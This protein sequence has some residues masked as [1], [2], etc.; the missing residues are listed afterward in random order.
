[1]GRTLAGIVAI[2]LLSGVSAVASKLEHPETPGFYRLGIE[3]ILQKPYDIPGQQPNQNSKLHIA[4]EIE[5]QR[6]LGVMG[7]LDY[8][9]TEK[10]LKLDSSFDIGDHG[11]GLNIQLN[12][13]WFSDVYL[14]AQKLNLT[15]APTMAWWMENAGQSVANIQLDKYIKLMI[16]FADEFYSEGYNTNGVVSITKYSAPYHSQN[17]F[18]GA[19]PVIQLTLETA[20]KTTG[21]TASE[22]HAAA[23]KL[24]SEHLS[25]RIIRDGILWV[26]DATIGDY[27]SAREKLLHVRPFLKFTTS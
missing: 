14:L 5:K 13:T 12:E 24:I 6:K 26:S 20:P 17:G 23:V 22:F 25:R 9:L 19:V 2:T 18:K 1:M 3:R 11:F 16:V 7:L 15:S 27:L 8:M 21:R 10:M 4:E